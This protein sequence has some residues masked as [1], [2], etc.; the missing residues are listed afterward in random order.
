MRSGLFVVCLAIVVAGC[1]KPPERP[2]TAEST[3]EASGPPGP[4]IPETQ[5]VSEPVRPDAISADEPSPGDVVAGRGPDRPDT[6]SAPIQGEMADKVPPATDEAVPPP[7]EDQPGHQA[8]GR[9]FF[10]LPVTGHRVAFAVTRAGGTTDTI[11]DIKGELKRAIGRLTP[12]QQFHVV[13]WTAGPATEKPGG[14]VSATAENKQ[15]ACDFIDPI[16]PVGANDPADGLRKAF[17]SQPDVIYLVA[18]GEFDRAI[19]D[20]VGK[21]NKDRAVVVNVVHLVQKRYPDPGAEETMKRITGDNGGT[22]VKVNEDEL[23]AFA[24]GRPR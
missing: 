8:E 17:A 12:D 14:M 9:T 23:K 10:G 16:I 13:F 4:A 7:D 21:L 22:C 3:G 20:L 11:Q 15:A 19:R 1:S 24:E 5:T 6:A 2:A 18:Y